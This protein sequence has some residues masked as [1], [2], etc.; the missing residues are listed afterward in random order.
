MEKCTQLYFL[1]RNRNLIYL[2][3][4]NVSTC[5]FFSTKKK[6][7]FQDKEKNCQNYKFSVTETNFHGLRTDWKFINIYQRSGV[8]FISDS[9]KSLCFPSICWKVFFAFRHIVNA[10]YYLRRSNLDTSAKL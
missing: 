10:L 6:N 8:R 2:F 4:I 3:Y 1:M 5:F 9:T 7:S